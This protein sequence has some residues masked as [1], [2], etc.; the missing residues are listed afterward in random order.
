[1]IHTDGKPTIAHRPLRT[2]AEQILDELA[3]VRVI[4]K[5]RG[6]AA[7][8]AEVEDA[9]AEVEAIAATLRDPRLVRIDH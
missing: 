7:L 4:A 2:R 6:L 1:M 8:V 3:A 9:T 5:Q